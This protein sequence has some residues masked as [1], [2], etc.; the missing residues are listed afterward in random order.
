MR[1][2]ICGITNLEDALH[3]I[4]CGADALGFV[5]YNK[6]PRYITPEDAKSIID[7]LPPFVERVGLFVNDSVETINTICEYSNISLAQIHFDVNT[8]F[9]DTISLKTLPVIRARSSEDIHTFSDRY[10]LVDAFCEAYGGSGKRLNLEWFEGVDCSKII[11]A[12]GLTAENIAEVKQYGFYGVDISSGVES[13]KGKKDP[14]KVE[15]F[16]TNAKS[17]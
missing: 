9:L 3:A 6:S 7:K 8:E 12:G 1:V 13:E 15:Q 5:F 11:L 14:V 17:I 2:K 4:K 10:R 16:I